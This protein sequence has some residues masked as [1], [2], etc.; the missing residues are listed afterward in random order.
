VSHGINY[1]DNT[2]GALRIRDKRKAI[3]VCADGTT[4]T[5]WWDKLW[6]KEKSD[7][8]TKDCGED[9]DE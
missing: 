6:D 4:K 7:H 3:I 8:Q 9:E 2:G 1:S 5:L